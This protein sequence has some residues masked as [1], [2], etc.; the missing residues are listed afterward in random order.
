MQHH[1]DATPRLLAPF[2]VLQRLADR[3]HG[4]ARGGVVRGRR[5]ARLPPPRVLVG[6]GLGALL[7]LAAR[8]PL[9]GVPG[10]AALWVA[11]RDGDAVV[12]LDGDGLEVRREPLRSPVALAPGGG[13]ALWVASARDGWA[14]G[15][16]RL[17]HLAPGGGRTVAAAGLGPVLDLEPLPDGG[18]LLVELVDGGAN[19]VIAG[20]GSGA[21]PHG[22][23]AGT[24]AGVTGPRVLATLDGAGCAAARP[25]DDGGQVAI[26][27]L[28]G[29][30]AGGLTL[31]RDGVV[32]DRRILG[33]ELGDLA[34]GPG[35]TWFALDVAG[36]RLVLLD[37]NLAVLWSVD[38]GLAA[39]GLAVVPGAERVWLVDGTEPL[40]RRYGPGGALELETGLLASDLGAAAGGPA[41][42][43]WAAAPGAVLHLDAA[44][45]SLPGQG[46]FAYLTDLARV[47]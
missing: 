47:P 28:V 45:A 24:G 31:L 15:E 42:D 39:T 6:L 29:D 25:V 27:V 40:A 10:A 26:E 43:L 2:A 17:L 37:A 16:H 8:L 30:W 5:V 9:A 11:D 4:R 38:H 44:G 46:G 41:G 18:A 36:R 12:A 33:G 3:L 1:L 22:V 14:L 34:P 7:F 13:G 35:G 32:V 21:G 19:R 23:P 20:G